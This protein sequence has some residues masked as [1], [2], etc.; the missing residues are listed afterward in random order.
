[1]TKWPNGTFQF[2][3]RYVHCT[4]LM[5]TLNRYTVNVASMNQELER[6]DMATL[7]N[8]IMIA[9]ADFYVRYT[10]LVDW[11]AYISS[12][13][14][15]LI[16]IT[17]L[18][19]FV[20]VSCKQICMFLYIRMCFLDFFLPQEKW[21][22]LIQSHFTKFITSTFSTFAMFKTIGWFWQLFGEWNVAVSL[23][24]PFFV[25]LSIF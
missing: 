17:I 14:Y 4:G 3:F 22:L 6:S 13:V 23:C 7:R 9:M 1:M 8:N 2:L 11:W 19:E 10:A 16:N 12:F 21:M 5:I 24:F 20:T 18:P 15:T 25:Y